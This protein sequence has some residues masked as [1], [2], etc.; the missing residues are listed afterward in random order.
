MDGDIG[1]ESFRAHEHAGICH[2]Q[3]IR[4]HAGKLKK[5]FIHLFQVL[6][7]SKDVDGHIDL[8]SLTVGIFNPLTHLLHAEV[9]S[10]C[11]ERECFSS[12]ID[13]VRSIA[14]CDFQNLR[15]GGWYQ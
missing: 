5:I 10:L 3:S 9:F 7:V 2:Q 4:L 11:P 15:A 12:D 1:A 8:D 6:V 14:D 13:R